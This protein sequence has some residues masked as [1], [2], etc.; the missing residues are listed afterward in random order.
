MWVRPYNIYLYTT[1]VKSC[2]AKYEK[3]RFFRPVTSYLVSL[4][5]KSIFFNLY[6][7]TSLETFQA[8]GK[9]VEYRSDDF[10]EKKSEISTLSRMFFV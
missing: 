8:I 9:E 6:Y 5:N 4:N 2:F 7:K 1:P 10:F 3:F